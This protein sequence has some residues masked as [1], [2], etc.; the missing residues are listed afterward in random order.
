MK[1]VS[2]LKLQDYAGKAWCLVQHLQ[3]KT[4]NK[5]QLEEKN[6]LRKI[7]RSVIL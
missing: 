7:V 2:L 3:T 4:Q 5:W 6:F 1:Q